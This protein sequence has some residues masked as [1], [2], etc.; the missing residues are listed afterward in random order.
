MTE[1][2]VSGRIVV[3]VDG[4]DAGTAALVWAVGQAE[5]SGADLE[6][7]T[8]WTYDAMLDDASV[9]R[10]LA[11]ARRA[12]VHE[13]EKLVTAVTKEHAG[14]PAQCSAPTGDPAEVLVD[15]AKD[16]TMLVV[17]SHGKGKLREVL[18]GSV[19]S[20]CLRHATCP[21]AVIP[22]PARTPD[23]PLGKQLAGFVAGKP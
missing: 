11:E 9:N 23:S 19:S 14:V 6:V 3:G 8:V 17:G 7:V 5:T 18:A 12:H 13:L 2:P 22:P 4:S 1:T 15:L 10:T 21:V 16:A 20:A